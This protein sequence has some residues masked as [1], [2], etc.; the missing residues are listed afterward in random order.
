MNGIVAFCASKKS[1]KSTSFEFFKEYYPGEVEEIALAGHLKTVCSKV[2]GLDMKYFTDQ[3]LKEVELDEYIVIKENDL[4]SIYK[5]FN[6]YGKSKEDPTKFFRPHMGKVSTT[7]RELLQYV[8]T[9][10]LHPVDPLIH[11]KKALV[12]KD[13]NKLTVITDL[14]FVAEY[15]F[16]RD[17]KDHYFDGYYIDNRG[18]Y[19]AA[20]GDTHPSER[21]L[22]NFKHELMVIDNNGSLNDLRN[23]IKN[24]VDEKYIG[25]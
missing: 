8:G 4:I 18:A 2:F 5:E 12:L 1:G 25:E 15:E 14:R 24:I 3:N 13:P 9:E 23:N 19:E 22:D 17:Q 7:P 21:Q 10:V 6:V 16:L 20:K 11:A